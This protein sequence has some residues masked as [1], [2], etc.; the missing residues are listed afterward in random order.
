MLESNK[1]LSL[2]TICTKMKLWE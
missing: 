1:I 2:H